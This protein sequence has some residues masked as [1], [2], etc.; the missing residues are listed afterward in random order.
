MGN[1]VDPIT[2]WTCKG[3]PTSGL[4]CETCLGAGKIDAAR[5]HELCDQTDRT[6]KGDWKRR[7]RQR[8]KW[9]PPQK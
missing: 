6:L 8:E 1:N 5:G 9:K 2:C 7:Q 4:F 3:Q